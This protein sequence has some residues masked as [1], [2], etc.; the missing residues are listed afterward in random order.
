[1]S[2]TNKVKIKFL[3]DYEVK[4][5]RAGTKAAENYTKDKSYQ[6]D[7]RSAMHFVGRGL[8]VLVEK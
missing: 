4:D 8:A 7:E 1:M 6:L 3:T 5:H 2:E